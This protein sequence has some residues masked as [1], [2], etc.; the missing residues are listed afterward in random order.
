MRT[1]SCLAALLCLVLGS[2]SLVAADLNDH[3]RLRPLQDIHTELLGLYTPVVQTAREEQLINHFGDEPF[4]GD[5]DD[6][7]MAA[8]NQLQVWGYVPHA[9]FLRRKDNRERH[10]VAC[11]QARGATRC[12]DPNDGSVRTTR[13]LRREYATVEIRQAG[14]RSRR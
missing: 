10:L 3:Q 8:F 12:L 14:A 2:T 4:A 1:V 9:R 7:F 5:C 6:Y 13:D 11:T